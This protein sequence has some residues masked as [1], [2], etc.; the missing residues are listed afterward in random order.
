MI[1]FFCSVYMTDYGNFVDVKFEDMQR[2]CATL[3]EKHRTKA[4]YKVSDMGYIQTATGQFSKGGK[5]TNTTEK[6]ELRFRMWSKS[7]PAA[8]VVA[9]YFCEKPFDN[10]DY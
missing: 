10:L 4:T 8:R 9:F 6:A 1:L 2:L 5:Q 7:I 3:M